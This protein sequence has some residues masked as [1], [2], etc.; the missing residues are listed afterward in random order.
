[1]IQNQTSG[2][3]RSQ[4]APSQADDTLIQKIDRFSAMSGRFATS[5]RSKH[6]QRL[7]KRVQ[8]NSNSVIFTSIQILEQ[9]GKSKSK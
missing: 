8:E 5:G 7:S 3:L 4:Q 1:M 2:K 9:T 6:F